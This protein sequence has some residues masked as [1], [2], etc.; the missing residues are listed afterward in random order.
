MTVCLEDDTVFIDACVA[1]TTR[2]CLSSCVALSSEQL[3]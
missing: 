1:E 3:Q 2:A